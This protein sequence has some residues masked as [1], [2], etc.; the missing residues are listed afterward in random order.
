MA[1]QIYFLD[2]S[3]VIALSVPNDDYH[4]R[5]VRL[6]QEIVNSKRRKSN[7]PQLNAAR[8]RLQKAPT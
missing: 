8:R 6:A 5:A 4:E 2:A 3:Y 7:V 1:S